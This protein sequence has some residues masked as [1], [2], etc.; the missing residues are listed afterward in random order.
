M[1]RRGDIVQTEAL[2]DYLARVLHRDPENEGWYRIMI[3]RPYHKPIY[4]DIHGDTMVHQHYG[5][6]NEA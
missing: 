4:L 5:H 3:S 2:P 6:W 1:F